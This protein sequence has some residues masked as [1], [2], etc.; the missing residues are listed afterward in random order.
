MANAQSIRRELDNLSEL[1]LE[2]EILSETAI[3]LAGD[4]PNAPQWP[5]LVAQHIRRVKAASELLETSL[6]QHALPLL[7]DMQLL[8]K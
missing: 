4:D 1:V 7:Q 5:W 6:R 3:D 2:A 8:T